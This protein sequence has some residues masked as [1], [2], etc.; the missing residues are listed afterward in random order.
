MALRLHNKRWYPVILLVGSAV[1]VAA[2]LRFLTGHRPELLLSFI[3]AVAGLTY[4]IYRQHLYETKLFKELFVEFNARYGKLNDGLNRI[5]VGPKRSDLS[6]T[7]RGLVFSYFNLCAEEYF[8]YKAGYIDEYVWQSWC[9]GMNVFFGH[10]QIRDLW[11]ADCK[12]GSYYGFHPN[13]SSAPK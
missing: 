7:E 3:G 9:H 1:V 11:D 10:P 2:W 8:F 12:A 5:L 4:F 13:A 6:E